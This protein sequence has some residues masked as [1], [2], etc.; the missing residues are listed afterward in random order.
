MKTLKWLK[1]YILCY[2]YFTTIQ[3]F[4][5]IIVTAVWTLGVEAGEMQPQQSGAVATV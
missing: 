2:V 4:E 5:N 3:I 1:W